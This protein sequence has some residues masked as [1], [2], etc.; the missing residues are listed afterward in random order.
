MGRHGRPQPQ[1]Q[2]PFG[3]EVPVAAEE[4]FGDWAEMIGEL[5]PDRE[6]VIAEMQEN[7]HLL[8]EEFFQEIW[9]N[10]FQEGNR[11]NVHDLFNALPFNDEGDDPFENRQQFIPEPRNP[12]AEEIQ[13]G[14]AAMN[15][16]IRGRG[17]RS[18]DS[19][20]YILPP[21]FFCE[22]KYLS[23]S[24]S[25]S[26]YS[27]ESQEVFHVDTDEEGRIVLLDGDGA[28]VS[29]DA[30][31]EVF[32]SYI[33]EN[34]RQ[35]LLDINGNIIN[36]ERMHTTNP[37]SQGMQQNDSGSFILPP[38]FFNE[39]IQEEYGDMSNQPPA[40]GLN[41]GSSGIALGQPNFFIREIQGGFANINN[42]IRNSSQNP[43]REQNQPPNVGLAEEMQAGFANMSNRLRQLANRLTDQIG[44]D[45]DVD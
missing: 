21:N 31:N 42:R 39:G 35:V 14:F 10:Q 2:M 9:D 6:D 41:L 13:E 43:P 44:Y 38:N 33:D 3:D 4:I 36:P 26:F 16:R 18:S 19:G 32:N 28:V 40:M 25:G 17:S 34:G 20:S 24:G 1:E 29:H 37:Q 7:V 8:G 23:S 5:A 30:G 11:E 22:D 12:F 27:D 45:E 15:N